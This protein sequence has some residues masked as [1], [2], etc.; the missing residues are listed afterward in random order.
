V[1]ERL[2][3]VGASGVS[4]LNHPCGDPP[5]AEHSCEAVG[6]LFWQEGSSRCVLCSGAAP[7]QLG[8]RGKGRTFGQ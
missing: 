4:S 3:Y 2:S 1:L 6:T 7:V 8:R 5:L